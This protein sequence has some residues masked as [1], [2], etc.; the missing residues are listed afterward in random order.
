MDPVLS[1]A[2]GLF[3][4]DFLDLV[5]SVE[6]WVSKDQQTTASR[7]SFK[8]THFFICQID[9]LLTWIQGQLQ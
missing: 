3:D 5:R 9:L 7:L 6:T 1:H 2:T 8:V 4:R